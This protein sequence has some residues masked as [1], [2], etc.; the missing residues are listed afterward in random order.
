V[1]NYADVDDALSVLDGLHHPI[2]P[3]ANAPQIRR[4]SE[5]PRTHRLG[6]CPETL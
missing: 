5:F 1:T 2:V 6:L 3:D 4:T